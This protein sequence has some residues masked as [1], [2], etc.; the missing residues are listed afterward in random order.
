[1]KAQIVCSPSDP[2]FSPISCLNLSYVETLLELFIQSG[3]YAMCSY[4]R[5][6]IEQ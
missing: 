1:M 4:G 5:M 6:D 2:S 3:S